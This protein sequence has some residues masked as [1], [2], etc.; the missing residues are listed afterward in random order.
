MCFHQQNA[1]PSNPAAAPRHGATTKRPY[2][3]TSFKSNKL[4]VQPVSPPGCLGRSP[5]C[6]LLS[7]RLLHPFA[8]L[9]RPALFPERPTSSERVQA[10]VPFWLAIGF[11]SWEALGGHRAAGETGSVASSALTL[12]QPS[13]SFRGHLSCLRSGS[14][15]STALALA[16]ILHLSFPAVLGGRNDLGGAT[17]WGFT[18][19]S[20]CL[21]SP[22]TF[23]NSPF[24]LKLYS[25][26]TFECDIVFVL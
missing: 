5:L 11:G 6:Q 22:H 12:L 3:F 10:A 26:K 4:V 1:Q 8:T 18:L 14:P 9:S 17:P 7:L 23:V 20:R 19:P 13:R 21:T 15:A 24:L 2:T 25:V 16:R